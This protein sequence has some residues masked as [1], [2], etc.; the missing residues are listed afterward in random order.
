MERAR[1]LGRDAPLVQNGEL[2]VLA[3]DER[4]HRRED[5][6]RTEDRARQ[7][8]PAA[9]PEG[10]RDEETEHHRDRHSDPDPHP[11]HYAAVAEE[12]H[13][14]RILRGDGGPEAQPTC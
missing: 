8:I 1:D 9:E 2:D 14:L 7:R 6:S 12:R 5:D 11:T 4:E 3:S 10:Q 13:A